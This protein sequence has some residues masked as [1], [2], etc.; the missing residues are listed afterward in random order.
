MNLIQNIIR[1]RTKVSQPTP[2]TTAT[3]INQRQSK[4]YC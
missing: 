1:A 2:P 3:L 4:I